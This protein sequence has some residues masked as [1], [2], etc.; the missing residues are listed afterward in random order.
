MARASRVPGIRPR[1]SL[2]TNASKVV[3]IRLAEFHSWNAA[4]GDATKVADLH[5]MRIAAKRLRYALEMFEP[6]FDGAKSLLKDLTNIQE[7]LGDIHDLDVLTDVLRLRLTSLDAPLDDRATEIMASEGTPGE[8]NRQLRRLLGAHARENHRLGLLGL[9]GDKIAERRRRFAR[10]QERWGD[11][12]L[13]AFAE[14]VLRD[15]REHTDEK[16][17]SEEVATPQT[18]I[19]EEEK[20]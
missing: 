20:T 17:L 2:R 1:K 16:D 9:L 3:A 14:Q 10:F 5:D 13:E 4:L 12:R 11:G 15:T 6:C 8:K 18:S 19:G 7:D